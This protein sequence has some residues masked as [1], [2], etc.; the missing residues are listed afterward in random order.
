MGL[1]DRLGGLGG[2]AKKAIADNAD[3][4]EQG[5]DRAAQA[6]DKR[7]GGKHHDKI[8]KGVRAAKGRL[9]ET[10][11]DRPGGA[12]GPVQDPQQRP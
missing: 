1:T 8:E 4:I 5:L 6:A 10:R 2:K 11:D 3:K 12:S 9:A 7:T